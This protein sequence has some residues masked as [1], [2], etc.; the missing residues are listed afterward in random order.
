MSALKEKR[1][2]IVEKFI[3]I[4]NLV[5]LI[6]SRHYVPIKDGISTKFTSE[7]LFDEYFNFGLKV[8]ILVKILGE[9]SSWTQELR[10]LSKI[11]S[12][13][14]HRGTVIVTHDGEEKTV[15]LSE[16]F[17]KDF[18]YEKR[19]AEFLDKEKKITKKLGEVL[20]EKGVSIKTEPKK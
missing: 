10:V 14:A 11:R 7:V 20:E 1:G 18:D 5:S 6:I 19:Y 8:K 13:F 9:E 15:D 12:A 17:D 16:G 2:D 4:E 3:N